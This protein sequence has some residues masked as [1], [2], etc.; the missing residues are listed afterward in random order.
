MSA[1]VAEA[2]GRIQLVDCKDS[3]RR[4]ILHPDIVATIAEDDVEWTEL[5]DG[6]IYLTG[7]VGNDIIGCF[8]IERRSRATAAVHVQVLPDYRKDYAECFGR[9]VLDWTWANT[10]LEK[11]TAEIPVIYPNVLAFAER[12]GF[13]Q[14]GLNRKCFWKNGVLNDSWYV[15]LMREKHELHH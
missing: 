13:E 14:E 3:A 12:M 9:A 5:P 2:T 10:S 8:I 7:F 4:V 6:P 11:L 15:G 1:V